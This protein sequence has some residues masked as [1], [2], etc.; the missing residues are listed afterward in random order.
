M[1]STVLL[2]WQGDLKAGYF[3]SQDLWKEPL[4]L[5]EFRKD[6]KLKNTGG[7]QRLKPSGLRKPPESES[8]RPK[9]LISYK[10]DGRLLV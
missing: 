7:F 4:K 8:L 10:V 2:Y 6:S 5:K 9:F 3:G 1:P